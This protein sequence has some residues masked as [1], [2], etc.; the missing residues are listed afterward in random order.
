[1]SALSNSIPEIPTP[2]RDQKITHVHYGSLGPDAWVSFSTKREVLK[3]IQ[4]FIDLQFVL[5]TQV[6]I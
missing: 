4:L 1:M 3:W 5:E 6:L 2:K